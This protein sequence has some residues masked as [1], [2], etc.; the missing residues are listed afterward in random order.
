VEDPDY[1]KW[2]NLLTAPGSSLGG[3]RPKAS[4]LDKNNH[5]WIAKFPGSNDDVDVGGWEMVVHD[6]A[7]NSEINM[8]EATV[9]KFSGN[10]YTYISKR[11]DRQPANHRI[12]FA[13]AMTML[14]RKDGDNYSKRNN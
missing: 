9:Q 1:L 7:V 2:L 14:G 5:L 13:S 6:L 3:A 12:H 11:F 4:V 8:P 10:Q